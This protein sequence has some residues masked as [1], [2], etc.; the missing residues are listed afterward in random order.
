MVAI[1]IN[2]EPYE[3]SVHHSECLMLTLDK[4]ESALN[5]ITGDPTCA[6]PI[7][8]RLNEP[9]KGN[10][11]IYS[12]GVYVLSE[13]PCYSVCLYKPGPNY[14]FR[15]ELLK[16]MLRLAPRKSTWKNAGPVPDF[17]WVDSER[18]SAL[19]TLFNR[20]GPYSSVLGRNK[21][22]RSDDA[23]TICYK[24][25][26]SCVVFN[27]MIEMLP[28]DSVIP[29]KKIRYAD[30]FH[31]FGKGGHIALVDGKITLKELDT[32]RYDFHTARF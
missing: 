5:F 29:T 14:Q 4:L 23:V 3:A 31:E 8:L 1:K 30:Y 17:V 15:D 21:W 24:P 27:D 18:E 25:V 10:R 16:F 28:D 11:L 32:Y 22:C 6:V 12:D 19:T 20:Y 7:V 9:V 13:H 2:G 26:S